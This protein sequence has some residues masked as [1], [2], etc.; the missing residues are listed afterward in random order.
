MGASE[1]RVFSRLDTGNVGMLAQCS[2]EKELRAKR[3]VW[4]V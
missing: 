3:G 1:E 2:E 4:L